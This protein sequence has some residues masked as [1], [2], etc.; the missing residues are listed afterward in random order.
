MRCADGPIRVQ[1]ETTEP[2]SINLANGSKN[3][4]HDEKYI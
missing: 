4:V 1:Q 3:Y 2:L